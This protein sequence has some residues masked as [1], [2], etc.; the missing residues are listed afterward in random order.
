MR[1]LF[2]SEELVAAELSLVLKNEGNEVKLFIAN[3]NLRGC[4][5][6]LVEKTS[7]WKQELEWVGKNGLVVFDDVGYGKEQDTLRKEGYQVVGGSEM[8]DRIEEDRAYGQKILA[9]NGITPLDSYNFSDPREAIQFIKEHL[10]DLWVVKKNGGH[11][12]HLSYVTTLENQEDAIG[13]LEQYAR[14]GLKDVNLQK[15]VS[16]V[17]IGI[18]RYFNGNDWVGPIEINVEHKGLMPGNLGPKTPEMG[19]IMWYDSNE[20]NK[21][22]VRT[23]SRLKDYLKK[24]NF[25]GDIDINCFVSH[26]DIWPLELTARFGTPSTSLQIE[27]H[28]SRW[29]DFLLAVATGA[30]YELDYKKGFGAVVTVAVPPFPYHVDSM[31]TETSAGF[32]VV[33]NPGVGE[34]E[35]KHYYFEEVSK[36]VSGSYAVSGI[37][38]CVMYVGGFGQTI[39]EA[40]EVAYQRI[41]K[42]HVP[43]M[44]YRYDIGEQFER[45]GY[46]L[47]KEWGWI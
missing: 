45:E 34:E 43:K 7:D 6:G 2:I 15:K 19:T 10:E 42:V 8:G 18:A 3:S 23:L 38:G 11:I 17:E 14:F 5:E 29:T 12:S 44:F 1:I 30:P 13:I 46:Q 35:I 39:S 26:N 25:R 31:S 33:F 16:G 20:E 28:N 36:D 24:I 4:Y 47:L 40:R 32:P 41:R 27:L 37:R 9:E 22:F 21:L